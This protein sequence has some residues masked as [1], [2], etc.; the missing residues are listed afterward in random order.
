MYSNDEINQQL[1]HV[2]IMKRHNDYYEEAHD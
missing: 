2:I 1:L